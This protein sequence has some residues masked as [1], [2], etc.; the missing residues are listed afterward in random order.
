MFATSHIMLWNPWTKRRATFNILFWRLPPLVKWLL[1]VHET[2]SYNGSPRLSLSS[3]LNDHCCFFLA[4]STSWR[5]MWK[6]MAKI[7]S[8]KLIG[9]TCQLMCPA[10]HSAN[11]RQ[12]WGTLPP[13]PNKSCWHCWE[14]LLMCKSK[15]RNEES[16]EMQSTVLIRWFPQCQRERMAWEMKGRQSNWRSKWQLQTCFAAS[17]WGHQWCDWMNGS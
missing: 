3:R 7:K 2:F 4:A 6:R 16:A 12:T 14:S 15:G 10:S 9:M 13:C 1:S 17:L 5:A 11:S 8:P